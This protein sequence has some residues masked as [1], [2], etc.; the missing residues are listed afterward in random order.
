MHPPLL[1]TVYWWL[2]DGLGK[3][4]QYL[5]RIGPKSHRSNCRWL[6]ILSTMSKDVQDDRPSMTLKASG[7]QSARFQILKS[8]W[9]NAR[10]E[11]RRAVPIE[12]TVIIVI[13][14]VSWLLG[15]LAFASAF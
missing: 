7:R 5:V 8:T 3:L 11:S 13:W 12:L 14:A 15:I 4:T 10:D 2:T 9:A 6:D 1:A